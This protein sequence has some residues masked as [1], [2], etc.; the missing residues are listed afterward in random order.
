MA[1]KDGIRRKREELSI[2][3]S[4]VSRRTGI[5][6]ATLSRMENGKTKV[7]VDVLM[8]LAEFFGVTETELLHF[9]DPPVK[10]T[11]EAQEGVND[12]PEEDVKDVQ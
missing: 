4:E 12:V 11:E 6:K 9:L 5:N 3:L 2:S 10:D 1:L 7:F 8:K